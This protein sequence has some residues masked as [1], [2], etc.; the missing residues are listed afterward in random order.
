M[1]FNVE[2]LIKSIFDKERTDLTE[3][4]ILEKEEIVFF[5]FEKSTSFVEIIN[6]ERVIELLPV[7]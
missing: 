7:E 5:N 2:E 6:R 4:E 1:D 3:F